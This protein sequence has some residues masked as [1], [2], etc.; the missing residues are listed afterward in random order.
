MKK[1]SLLFVMMCFSIPIWAQSPVL[2]KYVEQGLKSNLTL[3]QLGFDI[4]TRQEQLNQAK[5]LFLPQL[6]F[7]ASYSRA[8]GGRTIDFPVGDLL[9]PVYDALDRINGSDVF[10]TIT[11]VNEQLLPDD[12]HDTKV[13]LIQPLFNSDIKYNRLAQEN[14]VFMEEAR[15]AAFR[16]ELTHDIRSAYFRHLQTL[17]ALKIYQDSQLVIEELVR[18][19]KRL[20]ANDKATY[21]IIYSA[22]S[23]L[24]EVEANVI[25]AQKDI[26]VTRSFFNFLLNRDLSDS[27]E[28]DGN[29]KSELLVLSSL[30]MLS[31]DAFQERQ[32]FKQIEAAIAANQN[33]LDLN[34]SATYLPKVNLVMD[35]GFQGFGY[36]FDSGQD[37]WLAQVSM[38]WNIF[39]GGEKKSR[40][41]ASLFELEKLT[42]QKEQLRDQV[43]F[44]VI[45]AFNEY[46]A[47][48]E[49]INAATRRTESAEKTFNIIQ[50]KYR[51]NQ[52]LLIEFYEARDAFTRAQ[53]SQSITTYDALIKASELKKVI[54]K[55]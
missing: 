39:K 22:E 24:A 3:Q 36:T 41:R 26:D 23:A 13:R 42:S 38:S 21:D 11:N 4:S 47:A 30:S 46:K 35:A 28:V 2:E 9:N 12:F 49:S 10:P 14:L 19:N 16:N 20:V 31:A 43:E 27:I 54:S 32:E 53:L 7:E 34:K 37:Y 15:S 50:K 52:V 51:E 17:E 33:L 45:T 40:V 6:S 1:I 44:E 25:R 5:A 55:N 8:E 18:V 48:L 29:I